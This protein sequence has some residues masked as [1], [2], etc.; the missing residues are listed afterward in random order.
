M[1]TNGNIAALKMLI[2]AKVA[3][4]EMMTNDSIQA[5]QIRD[6]NAAGFA[7]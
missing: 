1:A 3:A 6:I 5:R 7:C 2:F 4:P